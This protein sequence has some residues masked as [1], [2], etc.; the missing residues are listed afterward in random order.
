MAKRYV[1]RYA[2]VI[3]THSADNIISF[4]DPVE[5]ESFARYAVE[6]RAIHTAVIDEHNGHTLVSFNK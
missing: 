1:K 4:S 5:A 3:L 2:V 6:G